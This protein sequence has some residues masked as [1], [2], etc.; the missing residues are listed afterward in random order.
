M[1]Q[2]VVVDRGH[3]PDEVRAEP[4]RQCEERMRHEAECG[5]TLELARECRRD[6]EDD[7]PWCPFG[8]D[9]VL[10]QVDAEQVVERDRVQWCDVDGE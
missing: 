6:R 10:E 8:G 4:D 3:V 5:R 9:D 1:F 7:E 2:R